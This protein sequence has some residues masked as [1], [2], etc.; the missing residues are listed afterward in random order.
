MYGYIYTSTDFGA[1]WTQRGS[2]RVWKGVAS[3]SD[4]KFLVACVDAANL[5][6]SSDYG[7][8]WTEKTGFGTPPWTGVCSSD[9]G[10]KLAGC[11][12]GYYIYTS[13]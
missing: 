2:S 4:G 12:N 7:A 5:Y 6:L 8:T 13:P 1:N 11:I 3:S 10:Y 9:D